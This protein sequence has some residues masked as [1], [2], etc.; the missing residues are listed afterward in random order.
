MMHRFFSILFVLGMGIVFAQQPH[1]RLR[2][3][4][5]IY[6]LKTKAVRVIYTTDAVFE[7]PNWSPD[8][9]S[10]L[11]NQGGKLYTIP[12]DGGEP[13]EIDLK[14]LTRCNNDKGFSPDGKQIAFSSSGRAKGSQVYTVPRSGGEPK[15]IVPETPSYFHAYSPDAK[16][17]A[18]VAQRNGNFDLF[19]VPDE[20]G[21]QQQLTVNPGY[22]DGPD[23]SPDGKWIYFNSN[24]SGKWAIWRMPAAGAGENDAQAQQVTFDDVE[25]WFPHCSPD[26]K[27][28]VFVSFPKG[29]ATHNDRMPGVE[30]RMIPLPGK[31]LRR[32]PSQLLVTFF[33]GQGT[34]NV[35]SWAPDSKR[36]GYVSFEPY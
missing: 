17:L 5:S 25:D 36:F 29:T 12:P 9:K 15:L 11:F 10:I 21:P 3:K 23:Y 14:G 24:R 30:L 28:L 22:D 26:G 19:R 13:V 31:T 35:N 32:R 18:F 2:S 16:Y 33:G 1:Q 4:L 8:G 7:A 20:G 27:W 34:I 6:D